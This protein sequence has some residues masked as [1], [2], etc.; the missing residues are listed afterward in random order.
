VFAANTPYSIDGHI[1]QKHG[2]AVFLI[3]DT[4]WTAGVRFH[5]WEM[6]S[7]LNDAK[8]KGFNFIGVFGTPGWAFRNG[9]NINGDSPFH[10][11]DPTSLN[12]KYWNHHR[13]LIAKARSK[14]ITVFLCIGHTLEKRTSW[15]GLSDQQAYDYGYA[16]GE[17]FRDLNDNILWTLGQD[18][19]AGNPDHYAGISLSRLRNCAEGITDGVQGARNRNGSAAYWRTFMTFHCQGP[20]VTS[21]FY[22]S[23]PWLD[24]NALQTQW[25]NARICDT[26]NKAYGLLVGLINKAYSKSPHKPVLNLE[27]CYENHTH[28]RGPCPGELKEAWHMRLEAFWGLLSG[29]A[30][31]V[32]GGD[33]LWDAR[34]TSASSGFRTSR[35]YNQAI[36]EDGR[37]D[38]RWVRAAA[39]SINISDLVPCQAMVNEP[40]SPDT[41]K[42]YICAARSKSNDW[43]MI[44]T[45]DGR[46]VS[47]NMDQI[48]C[49]NVKAY[50][51]NPRNGKWHGNG[52]ESSTKRPFASAIQSGSGAPDHTFDPPGGT[53]KDCDWLLILEE[54]V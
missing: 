36:N 2:Q 27:A 34:S 1:L 35:S 43:A 40:R 53:G 23:E 31:H 45:T 22:H 39:D 6:E 38:M 8:S 41:D 47:L 12:D 13:T 21:E 26:K 48:A 52:S 54:D 30:G 44:Y 20:Q 18:S 29:A 28:A 15:F 24:V 51:Y 33:G 25:G 10:D 17:H 5:D 46:D 3:G 42:D 9:G 4:M 50:W 49:S 16:L 32:Y 14:G 11:G 19:R 37:D 7:Y